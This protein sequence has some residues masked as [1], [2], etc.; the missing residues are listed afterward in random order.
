[1][2]TSRENVIYNNIKSLC[3]NHTPPI[4]ISKMCVDLGLS[5]S[6]GTKLKDNPN[7]KISSETAQL[8]ADYF[9]V[10]TD[11]VLGKEQKKSPTVFG[12]REFSIKEISDA[13]DAA[14]PAIREAVL[15]LLKLQ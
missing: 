7:K 10:S 14:D 9:K 4:S 13:F 3:D 8:I 15:R 6:L 11:C 5:K 1:M 2:G 12:E